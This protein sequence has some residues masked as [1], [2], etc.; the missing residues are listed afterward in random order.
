L[1]HPNV[2]S[3][4]RGCRKIKKD[5]E[6]EYYQRNIFIKPLEKSPSKQG[7][8]S[9]NSSLVVAGTALLGISSRPKP[10]TPNSDE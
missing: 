8:S 10:K 4:P 6:K 3:S 7:T 9:D 1:S 2:S 5:K